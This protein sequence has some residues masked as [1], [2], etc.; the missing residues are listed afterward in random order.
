MMTLQAFCAQ[1][2]FNLPTK[3]DFLYR[4]YISKRALLA[5]KQ[6]RTK[7]H[8][9]P[10]KQWCK[11]RMFEPGAPISF[12]SFMFLYDTEGGTY[13]IT[14]KKENATLRHCQLSDVL[15]GGVSSYRLCGIDLVP[16]PERNST[17]CNAALPSSN[18]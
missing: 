11:Q 16:D 3:K 12:T 2:F 18:F 6:D 5:P 7:E 14:T 9:F 17:W 4:G 1:T 10:R 8:C 13:N 15:D